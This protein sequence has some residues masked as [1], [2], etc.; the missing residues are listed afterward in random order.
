MIGNTLSGSF[1]AKGIAPSVICVE[2]KIKLT[3]PAFFSFA[4]KYFPKN[5]TAKPVING[6][7][8]HAADTPAMK[9]V[10]PCANKAV[11]VT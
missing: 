5:K 7:A 6:G 1:A 2:P 11:P 8:M 9:L 10:F 4:S 3:N